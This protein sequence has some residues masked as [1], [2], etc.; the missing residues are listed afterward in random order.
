[1]KSEYDD[2]AEDFSATRQTE[3]PEFSLLKPIFRHGDRVLDLGCGNARLRYFI[4]TKTVPDGCYFGLD[5]SAKLLEI[6]R[7]NF[8]KDHF[9]HGDFAKK[10]PFGSENFDVVT[11]IASFH[12]L[13][14][15][16]DQ[17]AFLSETFRVLKPGG[18]IFLTTWRIPMRF[19]WSNISHLR[20]KNWIVPFG[21]EKIPRTYRRV[22]DRELAKLLK[23]AGFRVVFSRDFAGRNYVA[24]GRKI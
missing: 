14:N 18:H 8:P 5:F 9:F 23:K 16:K 1:M 21:K 24:C 13:L 19:F 12:H 2:F 6:A 22:S 3:W 4:P 17:L 10:I 7:E 15:K 11:A 20:F